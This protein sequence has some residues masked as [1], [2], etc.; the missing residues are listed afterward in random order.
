MGE[1]NDVKLERRVSVIVDYAMM[2]PE[3]LHGIQRLGKYEWSFRIGVEGPWF[4]L[5]FHEVSQSYS[6]DCFFLDSTRAEKLV[7]QLKRVYLNDLE[8]NIEACSPQ[9]VGFQNREYFAVKSDGVA[10]ADVRFPDIVQFQRAANEFGNV[11]QMTA[12]EC[13]VPAEMTY[14]SFNL[15]LR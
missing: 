15:D 2:H 8:K 7:K 10:R 11:P 1:E 5:R 13:G 14:G 12:T 3:E 4:W 6:L 9:F